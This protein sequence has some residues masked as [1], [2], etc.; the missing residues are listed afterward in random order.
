MLPS[1]N[2][3][4][5]FLSNAAAAAA[6]A[7]ANAAGFNLTITKIT[8]SCHQ[9]P[10]GTK[11]NLTSS[12]LVVQS[13]STGGVLINIDGDS[14]YPNATTSA[15]CGM[16]VTIQA[17]SNKNRMAVMFYSNNAKSSMSATAT[18]VAA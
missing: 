7:N 3:L 8:S 13:C 11:I 4:G 18:V 6:N 1:Y 2:T 12:K 17:T 15:V 16:S 5:T 10:A 14:S 9:S